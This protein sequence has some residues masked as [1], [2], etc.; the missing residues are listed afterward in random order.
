MTPVKPVYRIPVI[1]A[2]LFVLALGYYY[3]STDHTR[4]LVLVGTVDANQVMVSAQVLG[5]VTR[6]AVEEGQDVKQGDLIALLDPEELA[7][8]KASSDAT[9]LSLR[10]QLGASRAT[11]A[12]TSGDTRQNYASAQASH[13]AAAA[14]L[15]G[16][17]T[18]SFTPVIFRCAAST[19]L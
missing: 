1:M 10:S 7:A 19:V 17:Y 12:S 16:L 4:E 14:A 2:G 3:L 5:R 11:F 15:A 18:I 8:A 6:L 9:A 13:S